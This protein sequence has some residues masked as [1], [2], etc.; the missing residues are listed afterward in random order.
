MREFQMLVRLRS[1]T[2]FQPTREALR[3]AIDDAMGTYERG[4]S[5]VSISPIP[6]D[7]VVRQ[8]KPAVRR[9]F[10]LLTWEANNG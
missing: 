1:D 8:R 9:D 2:G 3:D 6:R 7:R 4:F 10:P 5:L